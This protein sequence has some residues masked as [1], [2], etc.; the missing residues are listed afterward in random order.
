LQLS[1]T[2]FIDSFFPNIPHPFASKCLNARTLFENLFKQVIKQRETTRDENSD[3]SDF[4]E[5][6]VNA[7]YKDGRPLSMSEITGV[8]MGMRIMFLTDLMNSLISDCVKG[9]LLGGQHTSNVTGAWLILHLLEPANKVWLDAVLEEQ[10]RVL[11]STEPSTMATMDNI[12][13]MHMLQQCLDETLR[14]HPPFFQLVRRVTRDIE[15]HSHVIPKGRLV[16]ISP[17]VN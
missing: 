5:I 6:L 7:R 14:L 13:E 1:I 8:M 4:L 2:R 11:G 9:T 10:R 3:Y 12:T 15:Y 17:A 16:A